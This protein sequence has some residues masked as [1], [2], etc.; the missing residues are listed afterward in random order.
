MARLARLKTD[1][2]RS[3]FYADQLSRIMD[4][5]ETMNKIDTEGVEPM[6]HPQDAALRL[7][8][9]EI[10][11]TNHRDDYQKVAPKTQDGLYLVPKVIE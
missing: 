6:A 8:A 1:P 5:V 11:Q 9:D 3:E 2:E 10:T 4:L 7:R